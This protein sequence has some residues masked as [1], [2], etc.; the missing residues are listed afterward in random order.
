MG[1]FGW[2]FTATYVLLEHVKGLILQDQ[3]GRISMTLG[4]GRLTER[5]LSGGFS[6]DGWDNSSLD[7][8]Q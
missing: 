1:V 2:R 8:D 6:M 5:S 3:S 7:P 4:N